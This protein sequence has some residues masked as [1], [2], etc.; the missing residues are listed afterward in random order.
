MLFID[1]IRKNEEKFKSVMKARSFDAVSFEKI[2]SSD[3]KRRSLIK[4]KENLLAEKNKLAKEIGF[5]ISKKEDAVALLVKSAE[6]K[7]SLDGLEQTCSLA[8]EDLKNLLAIVPNILQDDVP[9]G[10][11]ENDNFEVKRCGSQKKFNYKPLQHFDLGSSLG[12]DFETATKISGSRFVILKGQ[13]AKLERVLSNFMLEE[14][15]KAGFVE[16]CPPFLTR[17]QAFFG[18]GQL[19]KFEDDF[20]KTTNGYFLIPTS[21]VSLTNMVADQ[22]LQEHELPLRFTASTPCFRSEAGSAGRDTRGMIRLHQF[23]K[24]ELVS[25]TSQKESKNE[26]E[27]ML[28]TAENI[29]QKLDLPYRVINLCSGDISATS[30]KTYDIEVWLPGQNG[31]RE[32]SSISNTLE[33]QARR[34]MARY[35]EAGGDMKYVH[36][37]NGSSLAIG[38]TIVAIL[39]NYQNQDGSICVP[40]V[41]RESFG[42]EIIK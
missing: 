37:L 39:E 14:N 28:K 9:L 38:R 30:S 13:L 4:Q 10:V 25:I 41:L 12:M 33:Y 29:L 40:E 23:M 36:T 22:I 21:E 3:E 11:D 7:A 17:P 24:V 8:E 1:W 16:I 19:P 35:K 15:T 31:Y 32:I 20:F 34:M 18:T 5:K 6:I 2:V 27:F 26:H 42:T